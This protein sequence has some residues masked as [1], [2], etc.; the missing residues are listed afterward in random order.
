VFGRTREI[1]ADEQAEMGTAFIL[2]LPGTGVGVIERNVDRHET[3]TEQ[4][5]RGLKRSLD[6]LVELEIGLD[7]GLIQ[8]ELRFTQLLGVIAPVVRREREI[9]AL[10]RDHRLQR[11]ALCRSLGPRP[12]PDLVEHLAR[13][14]RRP[15]HLVVEPVVGEAR[16]T[17]Q[18]RALSA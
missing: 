5:A 15:G 11:V 7:F 13:R 2:H 18:L 12:A 6:H 9:A 8:I 4:P 1:I 10:L 3:E 17:K 16:K 14:R